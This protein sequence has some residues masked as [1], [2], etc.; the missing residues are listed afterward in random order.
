MGGAV[1]A[2]LS[3]FLTKLIPY[4]YLVFASLVVHTVSYVIY[5]VT[6]TAWL[7]IFSKLLSGMFIGSVMTLGFAYFGSSYEDYRAAL[8]ALGKKDDKRRLKDK[9]FALDTV[10]INI[11]FLLGQG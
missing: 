11:G 4:W 5:A 10:G 7:I 3:G 6:W 2:L 1:G 8:K 9:L